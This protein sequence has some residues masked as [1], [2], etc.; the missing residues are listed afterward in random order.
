MYSNVTLPLTCYCHGASAADLNGDGFAD[1]VVTDPAVALAPYVL[2]NKGDGSFVADYTRFPK[3]FQNKGIYSLEL[4]DFGNRGLYDVF[5]G[6]NEPGT[7]AYPVIEVPDE[8]LPNNG[9]G[10]FASTA[11]IILGIGPWLGVPMDILFMNNYVYVLRVN[12]DYDA[13]QIAKV[14]YPGGSQSVIY[15]TSGVHWPNGLKW[16]DWLLPYNGEIVTSDASYGL[17][18]PP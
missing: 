10:S 3:S 17:S 4:V 16:I 5:V 6:G 13:N 2:F 1:L 15:S 18:F 11:P 8:I 12:P 7:T 9:S 14:A